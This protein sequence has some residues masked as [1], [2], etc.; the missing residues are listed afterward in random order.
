MSAGYFRFRLGNFTCVSLS[1]GSVDYPLKN[2]FANVP[3]EEVEEALRQRN[4][5]LDYVT[6][7]YT[8]L[9]VD[10]GEHRVLV[11]MGAGTLAPSTGKLL[12]SMQAASIDP[13][14]I[15]IVVITHAHPDHIGGTLDERGRLVYANAH[16]TIWRSEWEFWFSERAQVKTPEHF[17]T[18]ARDNLEPLR[19]RVTLLDREGEVVPGIGVLA[20]PGHTPGSQCFLVQNRL[21]AGDTLTKGDDSPVTVA[22]FAAQA[23]VCAGLTDALGDKVLVMVDGYR[24]MAWKSVKNIARVAMKNFNEC[25]AYDVLLADKLVIEKSVIEKLEQAGDEGSVSGNKKAVADGEK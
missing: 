3:I 13:L 12:T 1:D 7:P 22:D 23:V 24:Q 17:V 10:T 20:A 9:Y 2:F 5:P 4:L 18:V 14:D 25:N 16:Y 21:V 6:T 19:D 11:D 15:D 8:Y